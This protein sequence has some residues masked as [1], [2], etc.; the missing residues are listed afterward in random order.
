MLVHCSIVN[1]TR[2]VDLDGYGWWRIF[3]KLQNSRI[4]T[5][6]IPLLRDRR[7]NILT[8]SRIPQKNSTMKIYKDTQSAVRQNHP[9]KCEGLQKEVIDFFNTY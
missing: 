5:L 9:S 2:R 6:K 8:Q 1:Q 7:G 4:F 3:A